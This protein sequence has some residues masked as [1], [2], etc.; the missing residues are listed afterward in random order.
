[1]SVRRL[2]YPAL[3]VISAIALV[4]LYLL[5]PRGDGVPVPLGRV[6]A[7]RPKLTDDIYNNTLGVSW[8]LPYG[9]LACH[10]QIRI[11]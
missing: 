8:R 3:A 1:M 5:A 4:S 6:R 2:S 11:R 10:M 9:H 7:S